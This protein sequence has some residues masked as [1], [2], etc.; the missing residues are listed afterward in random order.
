MYFSKSR[1]V[2]IL[3]QVKVTHLHLYWSKSATVLHFCA[4]PKVKHPQCTAVQSEQ[5]ILYYWNKVV[6]YLFVCWFLLL[7]FIYNITSSFILSNII[8]STKWNLW[9]LWGMGLF[10]IALVG[11]SSVY[12]AL[13]G[14]GLD[15]WPVILRLFILLNTIFGCW[16]I[17]A[18]CSSQAHLQQ[19]LGLFPDIFFNTSANTEGTLW[20]L[21]ETPRALTYV[22]FKHSCISVGLS[23]FT[24]AHHL[25]GKLGRSVCNQKSLILPK[26][27]VISVF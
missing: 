19:C 18:H 2:E 6:K 23:D 8:Y 12:R 25:L 13:A 17:S 1:N 22:Q 10:Y 14:W 11:E 9:P 26:H 21:D 15:M 20:C 24:A 3:L 16:R 27:I 5:Y 4:K 7:I